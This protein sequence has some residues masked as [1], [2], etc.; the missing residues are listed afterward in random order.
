MDP[1]L[2][3]LLLISTLFFIPKVML[4]LGL[5]SPVTEMALGVLCGPLALGVVDKDPLL[6]GL[7][8][9]G[10]SALFLFA[11]LEVE[12]HEIVQRRRTLIEHLG[13]QLVLSVAAVA[14]GLGLGIALAPSVLISLAVMS[15]SAGFI[16]P[17]LEILGLKGDLG[18]W[19]RQKAVVSELMAI[20]G[21]LVFANTTST[22]ELL[23][24][25]G[26]ILGLIAV[27][28]LAFLLF[29][30]TIL[31]WAPGTEFS[32]VMIVAL[33]GAYLTH[34]LGVHYLVGA[35]TVGLISRRYL[36]WCARRNLPVASLVSALSSFRFFSAFFVPFFF[37]LV[38]VGLHA[39]ALSSKALL[40]GI[41]LLIIVGPLRVGSVML[42]RRIQLNE[43][44]S[45]SW[46][47]A[48]ML[49]PTLVFSV[50][51]A[52]ILHERFDPPDWIVGGIILYGA[53][54]SLLPSLTSRVH[55]TEFEDVMG[56]Q[57]P[58]AL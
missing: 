40:L 54:T 8:A 41:A 38:G 2:R 46:N 13:I 19:I 36:D 26:G 3:L 52:E 37:F 51:V 30:R 35:F 11:G 29:H 49:G 22:R 32:F 17:V 1:Y 50:A 43:S 33:L 42:H 34:H 58:G 57:A 7:A 48:L 24:G 56:P 55:S 15:S 23:L 10:I 53:A 47:V 18:S 9:M 20:A 31:W 45:E 14:T 4:R 5:P 25:F 12:V 16:I 21:V 27:V 6:S 39:G 28:P 44:W